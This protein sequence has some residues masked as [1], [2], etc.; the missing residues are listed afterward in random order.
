MVRT[1]A[2]PVRGR[3]RR[4][5]AAMAAFGVFVGACGGGTADEDVAAGSSTPTSGEVAA[6]SSSRSPSV[7]ESCADSVE[8][9]VPRMITEPDQGFDYQQMG[10]AT[11]T[12]EVVRDVW[13]GVRA[14][15]PAAQSAALDDL[16]TRSATR[17][18]A[19]AAA[20]DGDPC[21]WCAEKTTP[22]D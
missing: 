9:W 4:G 22:N 13:L 6:Q 7:A 21:G 10:L 11:D 5:A 12:W 20:R 14:L 16:R 1:A 3:G 2:S 15:P 8:Y 19:M 18:E 17:C